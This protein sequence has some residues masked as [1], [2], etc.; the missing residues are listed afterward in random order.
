MRSFLAILAFELRRQ[1]KSPFFLGTLLLF[2]LIHLLTITSTG[3]HLGQNHRIDINGAAKILQV[4][5]T[6]IYLMM[7]PIVV[8]AIGAIIGDFDR[9]TASFFFVTPVKKAHFVL[10]RFASTFIL[11]LGVGCAGLL[12]VLVGPLTPLAAED[13]IGAFSWLPYGF[14]FAVITVPGVFILCALFFSVAALTRS[15]AMTVAAAATLL[16]GDAVVS[17]YAP[18]DNTGWTAM[19]D[20]LGTLAIL[21]ETRYWTVPELNTQLPGG[22]LLENRLLWLGVAIAAM[23]V[24]VRRFRLDLDEG[25]G[26]WNFRRRSTKPRELRPAATIPTF[27]GAPRFRVSDSLS[28]FLSQLRMD[29]AGVVKSPLLYILLLWGVVTI[30][31]ESSNHRDILSNLPYYPYTRLMFEAF[32]F[33]LVLLIMLMTIYYSGTLVHRERESRISDIVGASPYADWIMPVSKT[34]TLWIVVTLLLIVV[35]L[36]SMAL[37]AIAGH[38]NFEIGLYL[39][40]LFVYNGFYY[41]MLCVLAV[42]IQIV[43]PNKW[44]GMLL[45]FATYVALASLPSLG[46]EHILTQFGIPF[47]IYSDMN[48]YGPASAMV[49][50]LIGYWG[51]FCMLLLLAGHLVYPRGSHTSLMQRFRAVSTRFNKGVVFSF[52]VASMGF[53]GFGGWIFYNTNLLNTYQSTAEQQRLLA[54]YEKKYRQYLGSPAPSYERMSMEVELFPEQRRLESRGTGTLRNNKDTPIAEFVISIDLRMRVNR[55]RVGEATLTVSDPVHGFYLFTLHSRLEPRM[56]VTVDWDMSRRNRGF[57]ND[58]HDYEIV[59]NGTFVESPEIVPIPGFDNDRFI[60]DETWRRQFGLGSAEGLPALGDPDYLDVLKFGVDSRAEVRA[61]VS[62]S[63][64]QTAVAPGVLQRDWVERGRHYFEYVSEGPIWPAAPIASARYD[65]ARD[66]WNDV[67]IEIYHHP[68][69]GAN[70]QAMMTTIKSTLD[71]MTR[72]FFPYPYSSFRILEY[73]GYRAAAK[74]FAGIAVYPELYGFITDP[75]GM[76]DLDYATIHELCH[77][78]W[79]GLAYGAKMQ[80]RQMLNETLAQYS[81]L[82]IFKEHFGDEFAGQLARQLE[83]NYLSNRSDEA[84]TEFPLMYTDDQGYISYNKGPLAF[85]ALQDVI[86]EDRVNT[87]LRR[88]LEKFAFKEAP[89]PTSRDVV[90]ELRSVTDESHQEL[91]TDLFEKIVLCDLEI[92]RADLQPVG[93]SFTVSISLSAHQFEADALGKETEVPLHRVVDIAVFPGPDP[94]G[95]DRQPLYRGRHLVESG[96]QTIELEV[97][98][99]PDSVEIDPHYKVIDRTRHNN[100]AKL[101]T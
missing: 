30:V 67:A 71:Y 26:L 41:G 46:A 68:G 78:W 61:V 54:D 58:G 5:S 14:G 77:Q 84:R 93:D 47:A 53:V 80:G 45:V 11:G 19:A 75:A 18:S 63:A 17:L 87:A 72:E 48:G 73:P 76:R 88:Y 4:I 86:G 36:T 34:M 37:Q 65:V 74:A 3:V 28:Q 16:A 90:N 79:G 98:E 13:P 51:F 59:N 70:V 60:S 7:M 10:G 69:H 57:V 89:F 96:A 21:V 50:S 8:F 24:T 52:A 64:G 12:G 91:I 23:A 62:T 33:G 66:R 99:P 81:T 31:G 83:D 35:M 6:Y 100:V 55:L 2:F 9:S 15:A 85:Y 43:S 42:T 40:S 29:V 101:G 49:Y 82:M 25:G 38:T 44:I 27:D 32:H 20:P 97:S 95:Q 22:L 1:A 39:K 92:E 94:H 56:A